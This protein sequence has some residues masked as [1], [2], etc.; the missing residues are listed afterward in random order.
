MAYEQV[1]GA[2]LCQEQAGHSSRRAYHPWMQTSY[3]L[4]MMKAMG[5]SEAKPRSGSSR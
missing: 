5:F 1:S 4:E 3:V 2:A